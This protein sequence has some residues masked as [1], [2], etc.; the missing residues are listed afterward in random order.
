[1]VRFEAGFEADF[2]TNVCPPVTAG[3]LLAHRLRTGQ[4]DRMNDAVIEALSAVRVAHEAATRA[5]LRAEDAAR[6]AGVA[7]GLSTI[8]ELTVKRINVVEDDGTLRIV[9]GNSTHGRTIPVRGR[10]VEHPG[11]AA[12]AGL[13]FMNDEGTE[14]GGLEYRGRRGPEGTE[15]SGYLTVDD[16]EQNESLRFGMTQ[17]GAASRK[18]LEFHD[19][20]DWSFVDLIDETSGLDDAA[21]RAVHEGHSGGE[22]GVSRMRLAREEDGSVGLVL[23]DGEGRDRLRLVVP[24]QG[25]PVVEMVAVDGTVTSLL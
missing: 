6:A 17:D 9:I 24:A 19:R 2:A 22:S 14:C 21:A 5:L 16:F 20:P 3:R 18:F 13:L 15:Q 11:R 1:M 12:A 23:R 7:A 25:D 8:D 10:L 4:D